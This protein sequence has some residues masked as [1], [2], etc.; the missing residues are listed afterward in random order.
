VEMEPLDRAA[1]RARSGVVEPKAVVGALRGP[2]R[3]GLGIADVAGLVERFPGPAVLTVEG[4]PGAIS[5]SA[6]HA[7][8]RAV[9]ES[10][11]NAA[12]YAP[13]GAVRVVLQWEPAQL[14]LIVSD[15]GPGAQMVP[16]GQ[17]GGQGLRGMQERVAAVG[18]T[19]LTGPQGAGWQTEIVVP[20]T[21]LVTGP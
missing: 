2:V 9:Q 14:R 7:I 20:V 21:E 17:G 6:G 8:Y 12:R 3:P 16:A 11:T 10:L 15:D 1:E 5:E 19:L 13:G 4:A 18:G